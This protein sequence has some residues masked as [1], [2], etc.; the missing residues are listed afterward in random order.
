MATKTEQEKPITYHV[1][2]LN[3]SE[4][5]L[6]A[7]RDLQIDL[8]GIQTKINERFNRLETQIDGRLGAIAIKL[9]EYDKHFLI[10]EAKLDEYDRRFER[11][12]A[13]LK[14]HGAKLEWIEG[15]LSQHDGRFERIKAKQ[16]QHDG[17]FSELLEGQKEMLALLH[18]LVDKPS[19]YTTD[20]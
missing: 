18:K 4:E 14:Y 7:I 5:I 6:K 13:T 2:K 16:E 19:P 1:Q 10:I 8:G 12:D 17:R 3:M 11:I 15:K 20:T 9:D